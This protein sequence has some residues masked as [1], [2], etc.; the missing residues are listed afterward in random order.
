MVAERPE[1][2]GVT[3]YVPT[4]ALELP[5]VVKVTGVVVIIA[6]AVSEPLNP[7][8][9]KLNDGKEDP[10]VIDALFTVI[11]NA[12]FPIL[13]LTELVPKT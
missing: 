11:V 2:T 12:A 1:I 4:D 13:Q 3:A 10:Y 7:A 9:V 5:V 6:D 8:C